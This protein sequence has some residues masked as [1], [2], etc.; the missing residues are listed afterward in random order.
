MERAVKLL[1]AQES[2]YTLNEIDEIHCGT[3]SKLLD[4]Q[5][6]FT[7]PDPSQSLCTWRKTISDYKFHLSA[8]RAVEKI[9]QT[10]NPEECKDS[11][12]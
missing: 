5:D 2:K 10:Q 6:W 8:E 4:A 12:E 11:E 3:I 7:P 9:V 1:L